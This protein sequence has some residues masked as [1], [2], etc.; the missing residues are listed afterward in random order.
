MEPTGQ[1]PLMIKKGKSICSESSRSN[2]K[3]KPRKISRSD[4]QQR[5]DNSKK[6]AS[7]HWPLASRESAALQTELLALG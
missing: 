7:V 6:H 2:P 5:S 4:K 1:L 3:D